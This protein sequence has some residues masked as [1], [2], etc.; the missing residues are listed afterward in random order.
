MKPIILQCSSCNEKLSFAESSVLYHCVNCSKWFEPLEGTLIEVQFIQLEPQIT[1][2]VQF[3]LPFRAFSLC[4][5]IDGDEKE[6]VQRAQDFADNFSIV[7]VQ[8]F[9]SRSLVN[10][11]DWGML[12]TQKKLELKG[13]TVYCPPSLGWCSRSIE[14]C[15]PFARAFMMSFIDNYVDVTDLEITCALNSPKLVAVPFS[16]NEQLIRDCCLG[17]SV[18]SVY[19]EGIPKQ[20]HKDD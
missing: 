18:P 10:Y 4:T 1:E 13:P 12:Y 3:H 17:E 15:W 19:I 6:R 2:P 9:R 11:F 20:K 8:A 16:A 5:S 14:E 7:Y